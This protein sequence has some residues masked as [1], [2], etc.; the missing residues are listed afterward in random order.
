MSHHHP[1]KAFVCATRPTFPM[2]YSPETN[3][4]V[5]AIVQTGSSTLERLNRNINITRKR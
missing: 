2:R 4:L 3:V 1:K 5:T